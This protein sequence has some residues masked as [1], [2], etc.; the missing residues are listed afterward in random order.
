MHAGWRFHK[1][2]SVYLLAASA[3]AAGR[4][5]LI[6]NKTHSTGQPSQNYLEGWPQMPGDR[7]PGNCIGVTQPCAAR[8]AEETVARY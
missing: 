2:P 5:L 4:L 1:K 8:R 3:L 6:S 7:P